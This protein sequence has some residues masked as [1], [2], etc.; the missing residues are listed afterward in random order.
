MRKQ[1][2]IILLPCCM[3]FFI[4]LSFNIIVKIITCIL[5]LYLLVLTAVPC[6]D[7]PM[8]NRLQGIELSLNTSNGSHND[9]DFCSPF[10]TCNCCVSPI[11]HQ[12][13]TIHYKHFLLSKEYNSSYTSI[14][15]SSPFTSIWQPPKISLT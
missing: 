4:Y 9:I 12:D 14:Y 11:I 13:N 5:P 7:V 10:C 3:N 2:R 1:S 6:I 8:D 15:H